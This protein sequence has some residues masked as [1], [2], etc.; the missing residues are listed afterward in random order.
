LKHLHPA[1]RVICGVEVQKG[2]IRERVSTFVLGTGHSQPYEFGHHKKRIL[3]IMH[4]PMN[5]G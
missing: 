2:K 4:D 1:C 5:F 3:K